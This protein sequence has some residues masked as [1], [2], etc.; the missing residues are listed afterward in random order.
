MENII[1]P[2]VILV[3]IG[4]FLSW[5]GRTPLTLVISYLVVGIVGVFVSYI[6]FEIFVISVA[7]SSY[8][9]KM[10]NP[11]LLYIL[12][13]FNLKPLAAF[14]SIFNEE[15]R[16]VV[17]VV[18]T[19][20]SVIAATLPFVTF[21]NAVY[22]AMTAED[23]KRETHKVGKNIQNEMKEHVS[24]NAKYQDELMVKLEL[25]DSSIN[26]LAS[27]V[28]EIEIDSKYNEDQQNIIEK[29]TLQ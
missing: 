25:I 5:L 10:N 2:L 19:V 15:Q 11:I 18:I 1:I 9:E 29:E 26:L 3:V 13:V 16:V 4:A 22:A 27:R 6:G 8:A 14:F 17:L 24:E 20:V 7:G 21:A 28:D 23:G 12:E